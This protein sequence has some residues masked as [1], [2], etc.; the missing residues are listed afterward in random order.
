MHDNTRSTTDTEIVTQSLP[1]SYVQNP[2]HH[3]GKAT[4]ISSARDEAARKGRELNF[5]VWPSDLFSWTFITMVLKVNGA[6]SLETPRNFQ[7]QPLKLTYGGNS[8]PG[9]DVR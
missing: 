6:G 7:A 4:V 3:A 2:G 1:C 9:E 8:G 5:N